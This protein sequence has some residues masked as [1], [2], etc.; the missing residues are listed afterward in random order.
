MRSAVAWRWQ[1][2]HSEIIVLAALIE[3]VGTQTS[4][5]PEAD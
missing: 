5:A 4:N 1:V 2:S 3:S